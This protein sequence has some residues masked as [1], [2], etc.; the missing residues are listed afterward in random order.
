MKQPLSR[1]NKYG[2]FGLSYISKVGERVGG[3]VGGVGALVTTGAVLHDLQ[4]AC[5]VPHARPAA[6][7]LS[8]HSARIS[9]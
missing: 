8:T 4:H 7:P 9:N 6:D 2:I 1:Q 3:G 5:R